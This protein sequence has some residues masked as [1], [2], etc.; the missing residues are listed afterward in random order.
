MKDE[1]GRKQVMVNE[2]KAV[3]QTEHDLNETTTADELTAK[4]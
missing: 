2:A 1:S 3:K 4:R